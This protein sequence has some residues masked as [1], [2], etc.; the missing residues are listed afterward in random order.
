MSSGIDY[1]FWKICMKICIESIDQG[2]WD[3]IIN[4]PNICKHVVDNKE[5]EKPW[6]LWT[7]EERKLAQ[8]DSTTNN[9]LMYSL[10]MDDV[11]R[12]SQC[13]S[14][15]DM[16]DVIE[17]IHEGTNDV[18]RARKHDLIQEYELFKMQHGE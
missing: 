3:A 4:E 17:V 10:N 15:N 9:I 8:Y 14:A 7:G 18:K 11:F 6:N 2:I 13:K 1:Q 5:V 12:V 16:C